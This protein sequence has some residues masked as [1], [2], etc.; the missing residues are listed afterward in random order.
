L[1]RNRKNLEFPKENCHLKRVVAKKI[2]SY[3]TFH[4]TLNLTILTQTT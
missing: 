1:D 4:V 2:K 3:L